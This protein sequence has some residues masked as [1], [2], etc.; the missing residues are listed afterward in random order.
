MLLLKHLTLLVIGSDLDVVLGGRFT[1]AARAHA[2]EEDADSVAGLGREG[3]VEERVKE[4]WSIDCPL[5]DGLVRFVQWQESVQL[6]DLPVGDDVVGVEELKGSPGGFPEEDEKEGDDG[7]PELGG[8]ELAGAA[9][10]DLNEERE[11]GQ[12]EEHNG[13]DEGDDGAG[14]VEV[15]AAGFPHLTS[16][17]HANLKSKQIS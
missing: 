7:E 14:D 3:E 11:P 6:D 15:V 13:D 16:T 8:A 12:D 9:G 5:H 1:A 17:M 10:A 4:R 2:A